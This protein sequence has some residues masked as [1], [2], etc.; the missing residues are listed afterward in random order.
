MPRISVITPT[1][2]PEGL[3]IAREGLLKQT[4]KDFEWIV[5][6]NTTG[7]VDFNKAMNEAIGQ[8]KGELVV[9]L[10]DFISIPED[11]LQKFWDAYQKEDTFYT[12]PVGD[13]WRKERTECNW[14][15]WEIDWGC[16]SKKAL[17][18]IG[19]FDE[20]LD[21]YWGFDNVNVGLR[22]DMAGYKFKCLKDNIAFGYEHERENEFIQK[23]NPDFHNERL[24]LI[25][26]GLKINCL[27]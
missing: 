13:D 20:E 8:A 23:R 14:Q 11:G 10:Q 27:K 9:S 24:D 6:I 7:E 15:E 3:K 17:Y 4:F 16:V 2:R 26:R 1:I 12:A 18:E 5:K 25:R 22:A 19:G 21:K